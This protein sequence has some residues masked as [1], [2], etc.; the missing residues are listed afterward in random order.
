MDRLLNVFNQSYYFL[1]FWYWFHEACSKY[2][3]SMYLSIALTSLHLKGSLYKSSVA[4][5]TNPRLWMWSSALFMGSNLG[6]LPRPLHVSVIGLKPSSTSGKDELAEKC[7]ANVKFASEAGRKLE[8][9]L[10]WNG[11]MIVPQ[12]GWARP[13]IDSGPMGRCLWSPHIDVEASNCWELLIPKFGFKSIFKYKNHFLSSLAPHDSRIFAPPELVDP[14]PDSLVQNP[15]G[16]RGLRGRGKFVLTLQ[17]AVDLG[18]SACQLSHNWSSVAH[19][20]PEICA[21]F[22]PSSV[23]ACRCMFYDRALPPGN[24]ARFLL[25]RPVWLRSCWEWRGRVDFDDPIFD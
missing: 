3:N 12:L 23:F 13:K 24:W 11:G 5:V 8:V 1:G 16:G 18:R 21:C 4:R 22:V 14:R 2:R 7:P 17:L 20:D 10:R 9:V 15:Y 19:S 25:H 6:V